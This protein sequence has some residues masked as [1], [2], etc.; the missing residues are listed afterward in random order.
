MKVTVIRGGGIAGIAMR[1][2][3]SAMA[4][5][6]EDAQ[7]LAGKLTN[8]DLQGAPEG[9]SGR[10]QPDQMLYE[11]VVDDGNGEKRARFTDENLPEAAHDLLEWLDSRPECSHRPAT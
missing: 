7:T 5:S 1:T 4:L 11:F 8:V 10:T 6:P 3:L 9:K 2:E